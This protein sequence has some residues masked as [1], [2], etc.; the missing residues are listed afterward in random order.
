MRAE[1]RLRALQK[2][3]GAGTFCVPGVDTH[4]A[5]VL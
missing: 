2:P 1:I 4:G 3:T 5:V